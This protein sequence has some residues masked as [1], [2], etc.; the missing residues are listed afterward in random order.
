MARPFRREA[1]SIQPSEIQE[2]NSHHRK[3]RA[4]TSLPLELKLFH[5]LTS[6]NSRLTRSRR[7]WV[8]KRL[9][10]YSGITP[11]WSSNLDLVTHPSPSPHLAPWASCST[12]SQTPRF[13][14]FFFFFPYRT[15]AF[16]DIDTDRV[17]G[18][19]I[20]SFHRDAVLS[21]R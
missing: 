7:S 20:Y 16:H 4:H 17:S 14:I 1:S 21:A 13:V 19:Y 5:R 3:Q 9:Q 18:F 12:T 10:P 6:T 8:P 15:S 11:F 2:Q